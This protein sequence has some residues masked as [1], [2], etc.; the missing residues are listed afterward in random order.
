LSR[1]LIALMVFLE[2]EKRKERR[3]KREEKYYK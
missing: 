1:G 3:E 2:P